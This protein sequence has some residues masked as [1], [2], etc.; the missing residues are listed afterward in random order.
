MFSQ[1]P[2]RQMFGFKSHS[3]TSGRR[4]RDQ[5]MNL[6]PDGVCP[7]DH[8]CFWV[9][10]VCLLTDAGPHVHGGH[11]AVIAEA[12][13]LAGHVGALASVTHVRGLLT[14]VDVCQKAQRR[15]GL[16]PPP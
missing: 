3:F 12:A 4:W 16:S 5:S 11:E 1:S 10:F 13:E 8:G 2:W 14:L 15:S 9:F 6:R 7:F